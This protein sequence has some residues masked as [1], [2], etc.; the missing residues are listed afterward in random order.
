MPLTRGCYRFSAG[1]EIQSPAI[2]GQEAKRVRQR[3]AHVRM[4]PTV[5]L[6]NRDDELEVAPPAQRGTFQH[7]IAI[8]DSARDE[9]AIEDQRLPGGETIG[10]QFLRREL[11]I[12]VDLATE[13]TC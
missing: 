5:R 9:Q 7:A 13:R 12:G 4:V 1:D 10:L 3:R 11:D 2:A 6:V 8:F